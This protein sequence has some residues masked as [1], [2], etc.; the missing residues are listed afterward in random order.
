MQKSF[1]QK[2]SSGIP[3]IMIGISLLSS[4]EDKN[5]AHPVIEI[6]NKDTV[7]KDNES[8]SFAPVA[9]NK[10]EI[11]EV[12]NQPLRSI[13]QYVAYTPKN[14][15]Q[16]DKW[17]LVIFLHGMGEIG[18]D[19]NKVKN[20]ALPALSMRENTD[21]PFIIIS[22]QLQIN[23]NWNVGDLNNFFD[24]VTKRYKV[25]RS[26]IIL[27][28]ISLGGGG[29]WSWAEN[30]PEIFAAAIPICGWGDINKAC[31]I[32]NMPIWTFHGDQDGIVSINLTNIMV[33]ALKACSGTPKFTIYKGVGHDSWTQTY[34]NSEV[35]NWMMAQRKQ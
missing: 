13:K 33:Q 30:N 6:A 17:P 4:C 21:F 9:T 35:I 12:L 24:E 22:P 5:V 26:Q 15:N 11:V 8:D 3:M 20:V 2:I 14:Y 10:K 28:G 16:K 18:D 31:S 27:T 34:N 29:T 7:V 1:F 32:K 23:E 19:I 25:D